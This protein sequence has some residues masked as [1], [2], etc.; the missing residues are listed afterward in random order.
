MWHLTDPEYE[1]QLVFRA[2]E[3]LVRGEAGTSGITSSSGSAL[4]FRM[5]SNSPVEKPVTE[6]S[7]S[8]SK[9]PNS[10]S[11]IFRASTSQLAPSAIL[12]SAI[13]NARFWA[14]LSPGM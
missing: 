9:A 5:T 8:R 6:R 4:P 7:K 12:L 2:I 10:V 11:S 14:S 1:N 13:R 3:R